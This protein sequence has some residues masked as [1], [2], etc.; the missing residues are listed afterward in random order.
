MFAESWASVFRVEQ[1]HPPNKFEKWRKR[2]KKKRS[3]RKWLKSFL[4]R[5]WAGFPNS[6]LSILRLLPVPSRLV[7]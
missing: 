5:K 6:L 1:L 7:S 2:M 4:G 3:P